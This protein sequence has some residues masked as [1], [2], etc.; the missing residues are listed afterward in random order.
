MAIRSPVA[1]GRSA[2]LTGLAVLSY[3]LWLRVFGG[4]TAVVGRTIRIDGAP[5]TV[6]GVLDQDFVMPE[7]VAGATVDLWRPLD[8]AAEYMTSRGYWM[9]AVADARP[10][11][12]GDNCAGTAGSRDRSRTS[13]PG[14]SR[15]E[16]ADDGKAGEIAGEVAA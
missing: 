10:P 12:H 3:G 16:Y 15:S 6:V 9:F 4:D 1:A 8:P 13:A 11:R 14:R 2:Q 5:I 7:A